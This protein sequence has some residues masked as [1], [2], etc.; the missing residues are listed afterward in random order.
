M[1]RFCA[2]FVFIVVPSL[3]LAD[4][5]GRVNVIDGKAIDVGDVNVRIHGIDA[6]E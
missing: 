6:P 2:L 3:S 4:F 1:F 5:S